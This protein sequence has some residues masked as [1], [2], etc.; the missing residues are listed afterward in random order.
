MRCIS[1]KD[2]RVLILYYDRPSGRLFKDKLSDKEK[3]IKLEIALALVS[4]P[5]H[6]SN[7]KSNYFAE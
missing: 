2:I 7:V 5:I 3:A 6:V 1:Q 4:K